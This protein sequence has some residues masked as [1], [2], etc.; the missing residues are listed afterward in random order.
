MLPLDTAREQAILRRA[1][2]PRRS[3]WR[4]NTS[5]RDR[6]PELRKKIANDAQTEMSKQQRE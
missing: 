3:A 4:T 5:A 1:A 2:W 6:G